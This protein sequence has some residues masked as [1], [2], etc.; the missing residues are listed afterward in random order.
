MTSTPEP[1][2]TMH[3]VQFKGMYDS[4]WKSDCIDDE[5]FLSQTLEIMID[6]LHQQCSEADYTNAELT[7]ER[8]R[9]LD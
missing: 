8:I 6:K 5:N 3:V 4:D 7:A 9:S 2:Y 1:I